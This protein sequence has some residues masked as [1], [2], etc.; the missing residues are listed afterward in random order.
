MWFP[1]VYIQNYFDSSYTTILRSVN[2]MCS[3][4]VGLNCI[5]DGLLI[6]LVDSDSPTFTFSTVGPG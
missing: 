1:Y 5:N 2:R 6:F 3:G 4:V